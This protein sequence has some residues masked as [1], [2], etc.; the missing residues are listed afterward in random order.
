MLAQPSLTACLTG[1]DDIAQPLTPSNSF[2]AEAGAE[3]KFTIRQAHF[4]IFSRNR[5]FTSK[6]SYSKLRRMAAS[7]AEKS[8]H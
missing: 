2:A 8:A 4:K 1:L 6:S 5:N 3:A 7:F